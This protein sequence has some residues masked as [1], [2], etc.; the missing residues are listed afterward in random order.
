MMRRLVCWAEVM[1]VI[2]AF[3]LLATLVAGCANTEGYRAYL[4]AQAQA[5][6]AALKA[7][8]PLVR[9]TAQPGQPIT[10]LASIEVFGPANLPSIQQ[11]RPNEWAAVAQSGIQVLG[12]V[13]GVVA[14]G[15]AAENLA[16]SVGKSANHGY[17]YTQGPVDNSWRIDNTHT[18]TVVAAPDPVVVTQPAPVVVQP[19]VVQPVVVQP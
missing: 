5:S 4:S 10:G 15:R 13:G 3:L 2:A 18:P 17:D 8:K 12:L 11:E 14:A 19:V 7:Q 16:G 6:A 1:L 9:I